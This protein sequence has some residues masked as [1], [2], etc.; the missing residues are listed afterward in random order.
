[1]KGSLCHFTSVSQAFSEHIPAWAGEM[2]RQWGE[3]SHGGLPL[4]SLKVLS[5]T[6]NQIPSDC[7]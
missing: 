5:G 7:L 6:D 4:R 1:M 2:R 3:R